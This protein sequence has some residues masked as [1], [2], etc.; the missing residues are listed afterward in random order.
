M[1]NDGLQQ[2]NHQNSNDINLSELT[3][4]ASCTT[5]AT[6]SVIKTIVQLFEEQVSKVPDNIALVYENIQMSYQELNEKSNQ[7]AR[8]MRDNYALQNENLVALCLDRSCDMLI[9]ILAVL[10][11]G[12][13]Y[14]PIEPSY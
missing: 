6:K 7:L 10:K 13:A 12:C 1:Q 4:I 8:Y 9:A 11:A 3:Q 5:G 14:V 2:Y